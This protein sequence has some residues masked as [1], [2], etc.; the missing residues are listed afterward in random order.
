MSKEK[1]LK[2]FTNDSQ[3]FQ[4]LSILLEKNVDQLLLSRVTDLHDVEEEITFY[5]D[6]LISYLRSDVISLETI[7]TRFNLILSSRNNANCEN[8]LFAEILNKLS[9]VRLAIRKKTLNVQQLNEL[10][11][12]SQISSCV[13]KG[14]LAMVC[15]MGYD[16][17]RMYSEAKECYIRS[18]YEFGVAGLPKRSLRAQFNA[19]TAE[20]KINSEKRFIVDYHYVIQRSTELGVSDL[21]GIC[22]NNISREYQLIGALGPALKYSNQAVEILQ[23]SFFGS[24]N[25]YLALVHRCHLY[26]QLENWKKAFSDYEEALASPF[27]EI[28]SSLDALNIFMNP[29]KEKQRMCQSSSSEHFTFSWHERVSVFKKQIVANKLTDLEGK[30]IFILSK[31]PRTYHELIESMYEDNL[32]FE[33]KY[34]RLR[35]LLTRIRKKLPGVIDLIDGKY[36]LTLNEP[37]L[38][39]FGIL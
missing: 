18:A 22:A 34:S 38:L 15:G 25:Y 10:N 35:V 24:I 32:D 37:E 5:L 30:L 2:P 11:Q 3:I 19:V 33:S 8:Y 7:I 16:N 39:R 29:E 14:E 6:V 36:Q 27:P 21:A 31:A 20:S 4:N 23:R 28:K 1:L 17:L 26:L 9:E 12:Y 13:V